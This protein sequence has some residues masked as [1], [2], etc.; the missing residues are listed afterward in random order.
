MGLAKDRLIE[1]EK[2]G[3][4]EVPDKYVCSN[5]FGN[6]GIKRLIAENAVEY[7]CSYCGRKNKRVAIAAN[8]EGVVGLIMKAIYRLYEEPVHSLPWDNELGYIGVTYDLNDVLLNLELELTLEDHKKWQALYDD[9]TRPI[10]SDLWTPLEF[11]GLHKSEVH[12][13]GWDKFV[14]QVKHNSRYVFSMI[15]YKSDPYE[16]RDIPLPSKMLPSILNFIKKTD[17][18]T[19]FKRGEFFYR[20]RM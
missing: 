12:K 14:K 16:D 18:V 8:L 2:R 19:T 11:G 1:L 4:G 17:M 6:P 20:V 5:C 9:L 3:F 7:F 10:D 13:I 15:R